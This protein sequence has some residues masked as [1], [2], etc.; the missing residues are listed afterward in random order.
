M[1]DLVG[2][3]EDQ[4]FHNEAQFIVG[5]MQGMDL[6]CDQ[7]QGQVSPQGQFLRGPAPNSPNYQGYNSQGQGP[8]SHNQDARQLMPSPQQYQVKGQGQFPSP[9]NQI[10]YSPGQTVRDYRYSPVES[11]GQTSRS[12]MNIPQGHTQGRTSGIT[13]MQDHQLMNAPA[14]LTTVDKYSNVRLQGQSQ[15][16]EQIQRLP[17][18]QI[19]RSPQQEI[20]PQ[21][22]PD[23]SPQAWSHSGLSPQRQRQHYSMPQVRIASRS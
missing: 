4:F 3:P 2:N 17:Q 16:Q 20:S 18:Q 22:H 15:G 23:T 7:G 12:F 11:Q 5:Q 21:M 8:R 10:R 9:G 6:R 14:N 13:T 1:S 19:Q